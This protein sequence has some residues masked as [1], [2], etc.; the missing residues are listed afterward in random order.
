[1]HVPC[2]IA[3]TPGLS[4]EIFMIEAYS[5]K[6]SQAKHRILFKSPPWFH[7]SC[8]NVAGSASPSNGLKNRQIKETAFTA[9]SSNCL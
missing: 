7:S 4:G 6:I 2:Q 8:Q 9:P 1:M 3:S 5:G